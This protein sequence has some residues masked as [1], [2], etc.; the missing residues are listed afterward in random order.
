MGN[1]IIR[2]ILEKSGNKD[3][4]DILTKKLSFTEL[5]SLLL[6]VYRL[7]CNDIKPA[8]LIRNYEGNRYVKPAAEDP[9]K[10]RRLEL[11]LLK[12]AKAFSFTPI[13]LS[14]VVP[15]G[16]C[17]GIGLVNQNNILSSLRGTEVLSDATNSMALY[18]SSL[19]KDLK[20]KGNS[21]DDKLLKFCTVHRHIRTQKLV[22][23][24]FTP[25]FTIFCMVTSR[26]DTGSHSFEK[27]NILEHLNFYKAVL[28]DLAHT[29]TI[30]L[31]LF[32]IGDDEISTNSF[33]VVTEHIRNN[34]EADI[35][36]VNDMSRLA[37]Q[38]YKGIQFKIY[39]N[40]DGREVEA[41]DGGFVDWSQKLLGN[42]KERMMISAIG[43]SPLLSLN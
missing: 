37:N 19:K 29:E 11:D 26:R 3:L 16:A 22:N 1:E 2:K 27:E 43:M 34:M 31:K 36:I 42:K 38:Y 9:L 40:I 24:R 32:K 8:D 14:P 25:H 7:R 21:G 20:K 35:N 30:K 10:L 41:A 15:L 23:P 17:S 4:L 13:E 28:M 12:A 39:V 18:I 5:N 6:E 33:K